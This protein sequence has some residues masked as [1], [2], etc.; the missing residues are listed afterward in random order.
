MKKLIALLLAVAMIACLFV[1]CGKE[2]NEP[3]ETTTAPT[4]AAAQ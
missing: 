4:S 2:T 1:G 3:E